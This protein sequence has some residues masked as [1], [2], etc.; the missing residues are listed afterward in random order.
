[1]LPRCGIRFLDKRPR[2]TTTDE[3]TDFWPDAV[4]G[5]ESAQAVELF[6]TIPA[7]RDYWEARRI[8]GWLRALP[9]KEHAALRARL[10]KAHDN[11]ATIHEGLA[12]IGTE[13]VLLVE[14]DE[15]GAGSVTFLSNAYRVASRGA[16]R[17]ERFEC[18]V[19][20]ATTRT[21]SRRTWTISS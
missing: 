11:P 3:T 4:A 19:G 18:R 2:G 15:D 20:I 17:L 5:E 21:G 16:V 14:P 9:E 8:V 13:D 12:A 6:T 7:L 1:M 10:M